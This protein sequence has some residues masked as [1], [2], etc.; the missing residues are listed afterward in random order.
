[1]K[2]TSIWPDS[3]SWE[4]K[5]LFLESSEEQPSED[6]V[7]YWLRNYAAQGILKNVNGILLGRSQINSQ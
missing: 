5:I 7:K 2:S 4:G 3:K 6:R 1:M